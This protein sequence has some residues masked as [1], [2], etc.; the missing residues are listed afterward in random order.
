MHQRYLF[1]FNNFWTFSK[2]FFLC[3]QLLVIMDVLFMFYWFIGLFHFKRFFIG[4][5]DAVL[6]HPLKGIQLLNAIFSY[7]FYLRVLII[8]SIFIFFPKMSFYA[9]NLPPTF[10][11]LSRNSRQGEKG[12]QQK[13]KRF[14]SSKL[15]V[16]GYSKP[17]L[18][19]KKWLPVKGGCLK[20]RWLQ[21]KMSI[22]GKSFAN[23]ALQIQY[24]VF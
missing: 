5:N 19:S 24:Y 23:W 12:Y 2:I 14:L 21:A 1:A 18:C 22:L 7:M 15:A 10:W 16:N 17:N 9:L 11:S 20:E 8:M 6:H 13:K 3:F 4:N